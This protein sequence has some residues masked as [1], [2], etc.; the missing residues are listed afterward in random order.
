MCRLCSLLLWH[1]AG[2]F[3][4]WLIALVIHE[5]VPHNLY[6]IAT[7]FATSW[8]FNWTYCFSFLCP[9]PVH[10]RVLKTRDP[11][12]K[13]SSTLFFT[14]MHFFCI[15]NA[16]FVHVSVYPNFLDIL[17]KSQ[18]FFLLEIFYDAVFF[19]LEWLSAENV[20][21]IQW[22]G[23][24]NAN[25]CVCCS[26]RDDHCTHTYHYPRTM[27]SKGGITSWGF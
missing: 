6:V 23:I 16:Y 8:V 22:V 11:Y 27:R 15:T 3:L 13:C 5:I 17:E 9:F 25:Y 1:V 4:C 19:H 18:H 24:I 7:P 26:L 14:S 2:C 21:K 20:I 10:F 12:E